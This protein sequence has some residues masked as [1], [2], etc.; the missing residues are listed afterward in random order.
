MNSRI[1]NEKLAYLYSD[2]MSEAIVTTNDIN[3]DFFI[4]LLKYRRVIGRPCMFTHVEDQDMETM[5]LWV[6][7]KLGNS[8]K[9][10]PLDILF[11]KRECCCR[12]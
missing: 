11:L 1:Q 3:F 7:L 12:K 5:K 6:V 2:L 4:Q 9:G 10:V 8:V